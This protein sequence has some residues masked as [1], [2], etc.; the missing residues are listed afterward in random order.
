MA[1]LLAVGCGGDSPDVA[2]T[3][4]GASTADA[5]SAYR[6]ALAPICHRLTAPERAGS[7]SSVA[8]AREA[9]LDDLEALSPPPRLESAHGEL[10]SA[11][12]ESVRL[13][14]ALA[15]FAARTGWSGGTLP[16]GVRADLL[17]A[18]SANAASQAALDDLGVDC[19]GGEQAALLV[20]PRRTPLPPNTGR[21]GRGGPFVKPPQYATPRPGRSA[22]PRRP[23]ASDRQ[24]GAL[25]LAEVLRASSRTGDPQLTERQF[26]RSVVEETVA[27]A[28]PSLTIRAELL[29]DAA[30]GRLEELRSQITPSREMIAAAFPAT[31]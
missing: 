5:A 1:A 15:G 7:L 12:R 9:A 23:P 18:V 29:T 21:P 20:L 3:T 10:L 13:A 16:E 4:R 14:R 19:R 27:G 8:A 26:R 2:A 6:A 17:D 22:S 25:L 31:I 11:Q 24:I 30:R 28:V